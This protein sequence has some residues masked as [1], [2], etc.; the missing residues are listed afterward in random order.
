MRLLRSVQAKDTT[1]KPA[2][3]FT[4]SNTGRRCVDLLAP[5]KSV[6]PNTWPK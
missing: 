1:Y 3:I 2:S 4:W 5:T 6:F